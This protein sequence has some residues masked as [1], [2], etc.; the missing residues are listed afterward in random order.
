MWVAENDCRGDQPRIEGTMEN[1]EVV[2]GMMTARQVAAY[3]QVSTSTLKA[4][5][6]SLEGPRFARVGRTIRYSRAELEAW[7]ESV[8][9]KERR[10]AS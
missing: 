1:I 3:L 7:I 2:N 9:R 4:W 10:R 8:S 6:L 5:R